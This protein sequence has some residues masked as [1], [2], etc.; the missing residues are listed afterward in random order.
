M[1][2]ILYIARSK[3]GFSG[4]ALLEELKKLYILERREFF[5]IIGF[6][7]IQ[8]LLGLIVPIAV[9]NLINAVSF[10]GLLQPVVILTIIL[11]SFLLAGAS[12]RILQVWFIEILQ[13][14]LFTRTVMAASQSA[15]AATTP[16][17]RDKMNYFV[18]L[19]ALQK[20]IV[21]LLTDGVT[22]LIAVVI[23]MFVIALYHP[24]FIY[25]NIFL[26]LT[27]GYV[28]GYFLFKRGFAP[29]YAES[30]SKY[31]ILQWLQES[32]TKKAGNNRK[33]DSNQFEELSRDYLQ[34]RASI[35]TI[36]FRQHVGMVA[37]YVLGNGIVLILG[38]YL[39]LKKEMSLGQLVAAEI[40]VSRMLDILSKFGKYFENF[41]SISDALL[42]LRQ[43]N[44][45][46]PAPTEQ[47]IAAQN[48]RY[49]AYLH[50]RWQLMNLRWYFFSAIGLMLFVLFLPWQQTSYGE[51]RVVAFSPTDRQQTI[52]AP[53]A[54]RIVHWHVHEGS[55]VKKGDLLVTISDLDPQITERLEQE[56]FALTDRMRAARSRVDSIE[57][58]VTSLQLA[59]SEAMSAAENRVA[60][61][62]ERVRQ[63]QQTVAASEAALETAK[64]NY[65]RQ[66]SLM[67]QGLTS[68]RN[69]EL[70]ELELKRTRTE[71]QRAVAGLKSA[72]EEKKAMRRDAKRIASDADAAIND[73]RA[74]M[75]SARSEL[76][77]SNED[78]PRIEMRLSR[79]KTQE[80]L[81]PKDGI[82][83]R[84]LVSHEAEFVKEGKGLCI[85]IPESGRR[86][87]ELW[88]DGND[89]PLVRDGREARIMFQGWPALQISG[90][91]EGAYGTFPAKVK[92][93][94]N[95]DDGH[96]KF[97]V[98]L[99]PDEKPGEAWPETSILRQGIRARG[100][101]FLN[102]VSV[103]YELWRKFNDFPPEIP[104]DM[105]GK[106]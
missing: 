46:S 8:G 37:I 94:D 85:L 81:A 73:A 25:F 101:V 99:V 86:A 106:K 66:K 96:G 84:L 104:E 102:R 39:V 61:A 75:Q 7:I 42:K 68:Q 6:G 76:A 26:V 79:Q 65:E 98:L 47:T 88:I 70:A 92:F 32:A 95:A 105:R 57:S 24:Y 49:E 28:V 43:L 14:R 22:S 3:M 59:R 60:M 53:V 64:L 67:E 18:E 72:E 55:L 71:E 33:L 29:S 103:G 74:T 50:P 91:P 77:R 69:V 10:G 5:R 30:D 27:A 36:V 13:R 16:G 21:S 9:G 31:R 48:E 44:S 78:L 63:A 45:L 38:G 41:F 2:V 15:L 87:V 82:I 90:W 40:I 89:V 35:F 83:T 11:I 20:D 58:R 97:R 23:G 34:K 62:S 17:E 1:S 12:I 56:R 52:E 4:S 93:V 51:G 19:F 100:W 80:V 54:G